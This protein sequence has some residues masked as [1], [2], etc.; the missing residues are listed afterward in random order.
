MLSVVLYGT[1]PERTIVQLAR[2]LRD[3]LESYRQILEVDIAG[4]R[5]DIVEIVVDPLLME[6]YGL[7]QGDIYNLIALNNKVVA[8]GFCRYWI[9]TFFR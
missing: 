9:W 2:Q 6:S 5:E 1:V 4:D 7:D 8:A 3:K